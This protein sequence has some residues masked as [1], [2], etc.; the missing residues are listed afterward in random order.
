MRSKRRRRRDWKSYEEKLVRRGELL[1]PLDMTGAWKAELGEMNEGKEGARFVYP[2]LLIECLSLWK[3]LCKLPYR[4][5]EGL[6]KKIL[7]VVGVLTKPDHTTLCRRFRKLGKKFYNERK[8]VENEKAIYAVFDGSGLKVCNRGEWMHYKHKGKR[9]GFV[10][11]CFV[12]NSKNGEL[13]DFSAT[14]ENV[15]EQKKIRPMIKRVC[16]NRNIGKLGVDGVGDDWKNF[17]LLKELDVKPAIK[18]RANA[19]PDLIEPDERKRERWKEARKFLKWGY[20]GWAKR[21]NYGQRWQGETGFSCFKGY[22]GEYVFSKGMSNIKAEIGMKAH[23]YNKL[24]LL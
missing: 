23:F 7:E 24:R 9:K 17:R 19:N 10:R 1:I 20:K 14:T 2:D 8:K 18:I 6:G 22:F 3:C 13:L 21:R 16:R 4:S 11:I 5:V 12:I 15:A